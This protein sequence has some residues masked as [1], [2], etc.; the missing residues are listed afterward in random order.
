MSILDLVA[1]LE[2][3]PPEQLA[4]I[5]DLVDSWMSEQPHDA[6]PKKRQ[7]GVFKGKITMSD[8]FDEPLEDFKEYMYP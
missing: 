8:D 1:K 4:K 5:E 6:I 3:L 7:F 2:K